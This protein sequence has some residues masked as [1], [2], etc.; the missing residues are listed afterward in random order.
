MLF[1]RVTALPW[2]TSM[3]VTRCGWRGGVGF[4]INSG[5]LCM[6][7]HRGGS[8]PETSLTLFRCRYSSALTTR[9]VKE[10][11]ALGKSG[12]RHVL[13]GCGEERDS[14][15]LHGTTQQTTR[16]SS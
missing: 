8:V 16:G 12:L 1:C 13:R 11:D 2:P 14:P 6:R 4:L 5:L 10:N 3:P 7:S 9:D 15:G